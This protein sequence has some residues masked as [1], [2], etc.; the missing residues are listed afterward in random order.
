[1]RKCVYYF[2][3]IILINNVTY[4]NAFIMFYGDI[5]DVILDL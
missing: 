1:M 5:T 2:D 4:Y 3:K